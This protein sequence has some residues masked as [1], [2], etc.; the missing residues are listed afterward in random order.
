MIRVNLF[1]LANVQL[2]PFVGGKEKKLILSPSDLNRQGQVDK[3][4]ARLNP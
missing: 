1:L 3:F 4:I 2:A